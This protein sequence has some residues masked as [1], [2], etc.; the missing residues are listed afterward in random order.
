MMV[1]AHKVKMGDWIE[2]GSGSH[3]VLQVKTIKDGKGESI[4]R[5]TCSKNVWIECGVNAP[6]TIRP[7]PI[8]VEDHDVPQTHT[9]T[10]GGY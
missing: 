5:F 7:R 3:F 4:L 1:R 9:T 6:V 10:S 8:L 2:N